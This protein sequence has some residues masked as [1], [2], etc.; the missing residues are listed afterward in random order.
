MIAHAKCRVQEPTGEFHP[1]HLGVSIPI[2]LESL[3]N[4]KSTIWSNLE[5][6]LGLA[7]VSSVSSVSV[8]ACW[9]PG[10]M[11]MLLRLQHKGVTWCDQAKLFT[12]HHWVTNNFGESHVKTNPSTCGSSSCSSLSNPREHFRGYR[13]VPWQD[14]LM[15]SAAGM[16]GLETEPCTSWRTRHASPR[17]Q[18][19]L[20]FIKSQTH[21]AHMFQNVQKKSKDQTSN[22]ILGAKKCFNT[23]TGAHFALSAWIFWVCESLSSQVSE[24]ISPTDLKFVLAQSRKLMAVAWWRWKAGGDTEAMR[25]FST[26]CM[27]SKI[28][29]VESK[30]S[31]FRTRP[32]PTMLLEWLLDLSDQNINRDFFSLGFRWHDVTWVDVRIFNFDINK[33]DLKWFQ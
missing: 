14:V 21:M 12:S 29:Q 18:Q 30:S 32:I 22:Q 7:P 13:C 8:S 26:L 20:W 31:H 11:P 5:T 2:N 17:D 4:F 27:P 1:E 3:L 15:N 10:I 19:H 24:S 9:L 16:G 25:K 23:K 28:A 33:S 6:W